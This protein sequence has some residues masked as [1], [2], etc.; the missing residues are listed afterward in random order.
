M[1]T[2]RLS[3]QAEG[4]AEQL[5]WSDALAVRR[6][7]RESEETRMS[8]IHRVGA[9]VAG[10]VTVVAVGGAFVAQGY[11]SAQPRTA[12]TATTAPTEQITLTPPTADPTLAPQT[13]YVMPVPTAPIIHIVKKVPAAKVPTAKPLPNPTPIHIIVTPSPGGDDGGGDD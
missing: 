3:I 4:S 11:L 5:E 13:I 1:M 7:L 2:T 12:S 8:S 10:M 6:K 9:T